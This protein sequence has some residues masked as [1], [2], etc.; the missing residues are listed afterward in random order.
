MLTENLRLAKVIEISAKDSSLSK[1]MIASLM[2]QVSHWN[3]ID[4]TNGYQIQRMFEFGSFYEASQFVNEI[5]K[6]TQTSNHY[7]HITLDS[8]VVQ[9]SWWTPQVRGLHQNDFVMAMATDDIYNNWEQVSSTQDIV[10]EAS[11]ES[12]PASDPPAYTSSDAN[13]S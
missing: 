5:G 3:L 12:F 11:D 1:K 9:V 7:P 8:E 13:K 6:T 4:G 2:E 10:D